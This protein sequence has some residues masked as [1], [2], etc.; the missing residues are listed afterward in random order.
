MLVRA[1]TPAFAGVT[2]VWRATPARPLEGNI[3]PGMVFVCPGSAT[4]CLGSASVIPAKAGI[5][6]T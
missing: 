4:V 3:F 6:C 1:W 2:S 5:H